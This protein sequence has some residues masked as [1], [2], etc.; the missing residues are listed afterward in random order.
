MARRTLKSSE[1]LLQCIFC[2]RGGFRSTMA[3]RVHAQRSKACRK[4]LN[5]WRQILKD[6]SQMQVSEY[7]LLTFSIGEQSNEIFR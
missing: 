6:N 1:G 7:I 3:V 4:M 2:R 5:R